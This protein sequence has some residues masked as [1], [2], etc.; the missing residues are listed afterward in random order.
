MG[1]GRCTGSHGE[2]EGRG[3][4]ST[5]NGREWTR[6]GNSPPSRVRRD[7]TVVC[8]QR[9]V[10]KTQDC[11]LRTFHNHPW[12]FAVRQAHGP[13]P[14]RGETAAPSQLLGVL[15]T[16]AV[17]LPLSPQRL[18]QLIKLNGQWTVN[19]ARMAA[20]RVPVSPPGS[21]RSVCGMGSALKRAS[22]G[23]KPRICSSADGEQA[24]T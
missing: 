21:Q 22:P 6:T 5:A 16:L 20:R 19:L 8:R 4:K 1:G 15:G 10:A 23:A 7:A 12:R 18:N 17:D 24:A 13:E 14:C 2:H 3:G 9:Q 11:G